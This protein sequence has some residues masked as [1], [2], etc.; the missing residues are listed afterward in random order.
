MKR[1]LFAFLM[2]AVM[3]LN[4]FPAHALEREYSHPT[5]VVDTVNASGGD[6]VDV[7]IRLEKNPGVTSIKLDLEYDSALTLVSVTENE[8]LVNPNVGVGGNF[9]R[10][11][12]GRYPVILN[13][14]NGLD[15]LTEDCV[16]V[17]LRFALAADAA[18]GLHPVTITYDPNDVY[19][20]NEDNVHFDV[21]NGGV[22][23]GPAHVGVTGVSL[24]A[25]SLS[26]TEGETA[27]LTAAV[28]P[29][30][31]TDKSVT[32]A[33]S[34]PDVATVDG[35][36]LVSAVGAGSAVITVTTNDGGFTASCTVN[37]SCGHSSKTEVP[38]R[39]ADCENSGNAK[40]YTCDGCGQAFKADGVTPTTVEAETIPATGHSHRTVVAEPTCTEQGYT[41]H[42]CA[43]GD[44]YVDSFVPAL[45]H[46][47]THY[48]SDGNATCAKDGTETAK[49]DRCDETHTRVIVGSR[50]DAE[51]SFPLEYTPD[52]NADCD[53]DGTKSRVCPVC[54]EKET[55]ADVGSALGHDWDAGV[56]IQEAT[57]EETG[58]R[59][60]TCKRCGET[61]NRII[62]TIDHV[63][64]YEAVVTAPTCTEQGYTT[65]TCHCGDSYV[66][67]YVPATGH[68]FG[69]WT[70]VKAA[71]CTEKGQERRDCANCDHFE[72]REI[73]PFGHKYEAV[74]T[75]PTCTEQGYTTHTC[76]CGDF[77]VDS[78]VPATGH[79]FEDG[80]CSNCGEPEKKYLCGDVDLD[81]GV[82]VD[83]VLALLWNVLFPDMY[84]VEAEAD[85][86][87][88]GSTDVDD[89]LALLWHVLF[90]D[91]YPLN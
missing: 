30:D 52:G 59:K 79:N 42:T 34:N 83:D 32:F 88:N 43:C 75:A 19:D 57:E 25:S 37:V 86:D 66:D 63:H 33:S 46:S 65:Y 10:S 24:S 69:T 90:P 8:A 26:L 67:S 50:E 1:R 51:H 85:F 16:F 74:V 3:L 76:H 20:V 11:P 5:F 84:P 36:G 55:V 17:T 40:Y 38:A 13:W 81:G 71:N 58:I 68:S 48:V 82:D 53:T 7:T 78:Y 35:N 62:P 41:T 9:L 47:F 60:H 28:T 14:Y 18:E 4:A 31:A 89:V 15:E 12:E 72:T 22:V 64:K 73:A 6:E 29:A 23:V 49:C 87:D 2:A 70:V 21:E 61:E 27:K 54:G 45:G 77:Y 56:V 91:M 80:T 39:P 44:S